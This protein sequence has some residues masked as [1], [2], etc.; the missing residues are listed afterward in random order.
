VLSSLERRT[1]DADRAL[2][3][4][5]SAATGAR[6]IGAVRL[7]QAELAVARGLIGI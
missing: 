6:A 3:G 4:A 5:E 1:A 2:R 7:A